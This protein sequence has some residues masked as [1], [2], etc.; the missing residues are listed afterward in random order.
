ML[1]ELTQHCLYSYTRR[2][3]GV[4]ST[5]LKTQVLNFFAQLIPGLELDKAR[6]TAEPPGRLKP[7]D[8][9]YHA[10][11]PLEQRR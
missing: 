9:F 8:R 2:F 6:N 10:P 1:N 11:K 5:K 7:K 3:V 4:I